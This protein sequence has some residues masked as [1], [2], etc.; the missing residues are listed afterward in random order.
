MPTK[1]DTKTRIVDATWKLFNEM[2]PKSPTLGQI[3]KEAGVSRQAV[4][5]HFENR[6]NLFG[7]TVR[8]MR[9]KVGTAERL[10]AAREV[11]PELVLP[12]WVDK[13]FELYEEILPMGRTYLA[14]AHADDAGKQGW[15]FMV[16]RVRLSVTYVIERFESLG[17]LQPKWTVETATDWL[18]SRIDFAMWHLIVNELGWTHEQAVIRTV[19][20]LEADLLVGD[21]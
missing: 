14:A 18:Y 10:K 9:E 2:S 20:S 17:M 11:A 21:S 1:S 5:L 15:D 4:Y 3:A 8:I 7:E 6:M 12:S 16:S 19:E 13:L